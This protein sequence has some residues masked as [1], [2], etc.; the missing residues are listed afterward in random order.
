[1]RPDDCLGTLCELMTVCF[2]VLCDVSCCENISLV[3]TQHSSNLNSGE[4]RESGIERERRGV[5]DER[6]N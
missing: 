6:V 5:G 3:A 1:M 4:N 2:K